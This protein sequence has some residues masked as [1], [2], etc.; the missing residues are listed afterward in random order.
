MYAVSAV[1]NCVVTEVWREALGETETQ[2]GA[3]GIKHVG[4]HG[5]EKV[6]AVLSPP[7]GPKRDLFVSINNDCGGEDGG[8]LYHSRGRAQ[9]HS[10]S[11]TC[12]H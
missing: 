4:G 3:G 11:H 2:R 5:G 7:T 6:S 1:C 12:T 8:Q 10:C 9:T